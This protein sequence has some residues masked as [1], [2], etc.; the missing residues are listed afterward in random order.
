MRVVVQ[1]FGGSSV[2]TPQQRRQAADR[3]REALQEGFRV[4]V[5][6]SAMGRAGDPYATDTLLSLL[7]EGVDPDARERD[8]L[9]ACGEVVAAVVLAHTLR[10]EG[11]PA[12]AL[13]GR[14]AGIITDANFGNARV[15]RVK[16][17]AVV[18]HLEQGRVVVVAGF[19]G[20][21]EDGQ[22]TTLGRGGSDTT[23]AVL[24]AALGAEYVDIFT[25]VPGVF[26]ADPRLVPDAAV[27]ERLTFREIVEMAHSGA[28]VVH[29]RAV[30]IAMEHRIPLRIRPADGCSPGTL[31]AGPPSRRSP[32]FHVQLDRVVTGIAAVP[33]RTLFRLPAL[34]PGGMGPRA[35]ELFEGL[36]KNHVSIDM[37]DVSEEGIG[38]VVAQED[39]GRSQRLM[40]GLGVEYRVLS[41]LTKVSVVGAGMHGVP[42]VMARV[43]RALC[44][45]GAA[46][47]ATTDSHANIACLVR[48]E[49]AARVVQALHD[50]FSLGAH[51]Q[52]TGGDGR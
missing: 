48:T 8:M 37:I 6:V 20:V 4:V 41:G 39:Q 40:D 3:V 10:A 15:R 43:A 35:L 50:E 17:D 45:A 28:K 25:D 36:G 18:R 27:L 26:T 42:G 21:T 34:D 13:T 16:P 1:K 30:E 33:G 47:Y 14:D 2:V 29:P 9:A 7:P 38:F 19:Q 44:A 12:V 46:V 32:E 49:D 51:Q 31:I 11:I 24:G 5:V 22:V 52:R 23:A